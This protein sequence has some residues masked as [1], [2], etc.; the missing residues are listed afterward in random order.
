MGGINKIERVGDTSTSFNG[1]RM[2]IIEY[3]GAN[4]ISIKFQ[5][6][7][8]VRNKKY[9][10]FKM[11]NILNPN[12]FKNTY[13]G[14]ERVNNQGC[15]MKIIKYLDADNIDIKFLDKD[16]SIIKNTTTGRFKEGSISNPYFKTLYGIGY[17]GEVVS[18]PKSY[19]C[20]NSMITRCYNKKY[21]KKSPTYVGCTVCEEWHNY[22]L[23]KKWYDKNYYKIDNEKM[24]LDKDILVK[25]N[26]DYNPKTCV[27]VTNIINTIFTKMDVNNKNN[28]FGV[29]EVSKNHYLS[30]ITKKSKVSYL[31]YYN[32][33]Q[34]AFLKYKEE[35]EKYI[36]QIADEYKDKIPKK[37]YTAMYY[38]KI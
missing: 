4:N 29:S 35:K 25:G 17:I 1:E 11:G 30:R 23:F 22:S 18:E 19:R 13:L 12:F 36:K 9:C 37:L 27:F 2:D 38:Y 3:F 32:T 8:I 28:L 7:T 33:K 14:M 31:G 24:Y 5:D 15:K 34:D 6:G 26:K 21:Q 16:E 10:N 20:W